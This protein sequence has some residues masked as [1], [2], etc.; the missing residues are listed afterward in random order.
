MKTTT[1]ISSSPPPVITRDAPVNRHPR[2]RRWREKNGSATAAVGTPVR[3]KHAT[4]SGHG[5]GHGGREGRVSGYF[6]H[7]DISGYL[8]DINTGYELWLWPCDVQV[9]GGDEPDDNAPV[10]R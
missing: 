1:L 3:V 2:E 6:N 10:T 7:T 9:L 8:V 4:L 5:A